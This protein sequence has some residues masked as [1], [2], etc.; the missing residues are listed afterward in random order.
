[1]D[2][3]ETAASLRVP[4]RLEV[5]LGADSVFI[6]HEIDGSGH[7]IW[8]RFL[9]G[10]TEYKNSFPVSATAGGLRISRSGGAVSVYLL[11]A[12]GTWGAPLASRSGLAAVAP[13]AVRLVQMARQDEDVSLQAVIDDFRAVG[14]MS[15]YRDQGTLLPSHTY[16]YRVRSVNSAT[17][18][19]EWNGLYSN[20]ASE[21]TNPAVPQLSATAPGA[22]Q[23][24]LSWTDP[25]DND[26]FVLERRIVSGAYIVVRTLAAGVTSYTDTRN[27]DPGGS[28]TY[29]IRSYRDDNGTT[30]Y[31]PYDSVTVTTPASGENTTCVINP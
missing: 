26:G 18:C 17:T 31:S 28:Y 22:R 10:G 9:E 1:M 30:S 8:W 27:I 15:A 19:N 23:I 3:S 21:L 11:Q 14:T 6:G 12:D 29:R 13:T 20:T 7:R 4:L 25:G 16:F 24:D 2:G 5:D